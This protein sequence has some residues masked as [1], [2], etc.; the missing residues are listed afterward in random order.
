[1]IKKL[2][3]VNKVSFVYLSLS[4]YLAGLIGLSIPASQPLFQFLTPFHLLSSLLMIWFFQ[5]KKDSKFYFG[6]AFLI[7]FGFLIEVLGVQTGLIFG[8]YQYL[9]TLGIKIWDVPPIIGVN[10]FLLVYCAISLMNKY[11]SNDIHDFSKAVIGAFFLVSF[12]FIAEPVAISQQM[13]EWNRMIPPIQNYIAWYL[14]S[15]FL[16]FVLL[17][18]KINT[19]NFITEYILAF[20]VAFFVVLRIMLLF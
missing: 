8:E 7:I 3:E 1:M 11:L 16:C 6:A 2:S 17:K 15:F 14:V 18:L 5:E 12:D 20:Q 13:W 10:W 9:T 19:Q 4:M